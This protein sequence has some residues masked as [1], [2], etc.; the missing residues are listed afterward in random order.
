MKRWYAIVEGDTGE[1]LWPDGLVVLETIDG[2]HED[3]AHARARFFAAT[4]KRPHRVIAV[5]EVKTYKD[6]FM[7]IVDSLH[8][9]IRGI[10][11]FTDKAKSLMDGQ[12]AVQPEPLPPPPLPGNTL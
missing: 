5:Y 7:E 3:I 4:T 10:V 12:T 1:E 2:E 11:K 9:K 6:I 8:E